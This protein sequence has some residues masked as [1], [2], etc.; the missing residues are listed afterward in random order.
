VFAEV[1]ARCPQAELDE[2]AD[3]DH[4]VTLD[5]PTGFIQVARAWLSKQR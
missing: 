2:V 4:H 5:N 1:K 3:S